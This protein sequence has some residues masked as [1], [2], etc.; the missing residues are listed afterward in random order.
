[1]S[2][3][4]MQDKYC[5]HCFDIHHMHSQYKGNHKSGGAAEGCVTSFVAAAASRHLCILALNRV[6]V[7][8][9]TTIIVLRVGVIGYPVPRQSCFMLPRR[10]CHAR[11]G[12]FGG[13]P[14]HPIV[15]GLL[16][17][18]WGFLNNEQSR[19][20]HIAFWRFLVKFAES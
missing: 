16:F 17:S 1:M 12:G 19:S 2:N 20:V 8:A 9:V 14:G 6:N 18:P 4:A 5:D 3:T 15:G 10:S 7:V 11:A 13:P